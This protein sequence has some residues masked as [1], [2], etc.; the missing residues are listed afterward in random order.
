MEC[1][2]DQKNAYELIIKGVNKMQCHRSY[3]YMCSLLSHLVQRQ[4]FQNNNGCVLSHAICLD[5]CMC[6]SQQDM[7]FVTFEEC[8]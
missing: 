3:V 1:H 7:A 8:W 2:Y 6:H 4:I 5:I